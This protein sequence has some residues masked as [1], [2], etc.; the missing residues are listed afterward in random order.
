MDNLADARVSIKRP[1]GS[2]QSQQS[3]YLLENEK[4]NHASNPSHPRISYWTRTSVGGHGHWT[5]TGYS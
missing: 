1:G 5:V 4:V 2:N 3:A